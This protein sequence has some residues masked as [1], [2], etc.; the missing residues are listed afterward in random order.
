MK[1]EK[2]KRTQFEIITLFEEVCR[3][4]TDSSLLKRAQEKKLISITYTNPRDFTDDPHR[5]V[6]D[7]AYGGG[8]GM[9]MKAEPVLKALRQKK[10][11]PK[12]KGEKSRIILL[13]LR[14]KKFD[15]PAARRLAGYD[16]LTLICGRYEGIDER[17]AEYVADEELSIGDYVLMGGELAA[18]VVLEAVSRHIPGVLGKSESLEEVKGSYPVYTRPEVIKY[19]GKAWRVPKV[20]LSGDEAKISKWREG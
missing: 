20:L 7:R 13:S 17:I 11:W 19:K 4:C 8:P 16:R 3:P 9:V 6:D 1:T 2:H 14:G 12:K 10:I 18:L 5:T 15:A